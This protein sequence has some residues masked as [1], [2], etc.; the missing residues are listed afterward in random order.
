MRALRAIDEL[1]L[2]AIIYLKDEHENNDWRTDLFKE[3][4]KGVQELSKNFVPIIWGSVEDEAYG[5]SIGIPL[6][7]LIGAEKSDLP[8][9]WV[10]LAD[11]Y[12][13]FKYEGPADGPE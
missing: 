9:F 11:N 13:G 2:Y 6:M 5:E 8:S 10:Y 7:E 12:Q 1:G 4:G 3:A